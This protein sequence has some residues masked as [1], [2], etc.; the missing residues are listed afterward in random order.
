MCRRRPRT[1][2]RDPGPQQLFQPAGGHCRIQSLLGRVPGRSLQSVHSI[3]RRAHHRNERFD[4]RRGRANQHGVRILFCDSGHRRG[5]LRSQFT[6]ER[7]GRCQRFGHHAVD[8][9]NQP[10]CAKRL[11]LQN[12]VVTCATTRALLRL[13]TNA[14]L[15]PK[16]CGSPGATPK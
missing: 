8:V 3:Q 14:I 7:R 9:A 12:S 10:E 11:Q 4:P 13:L 16:N 2:S 1:A 5:R 6:H 15:N